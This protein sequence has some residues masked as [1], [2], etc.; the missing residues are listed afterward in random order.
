MLLPGTSCRAEA[1]EVGLIVKESAL[2]SQAEVPT[3]YVWQNFHI[4]GPPF[5]CPNYEETIKHLSSKMVLF[6]A[7]NKRR[8]FFKNLFY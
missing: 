1:E 2:F 6:R 8:G 4:L 7:L 3:T 5:L